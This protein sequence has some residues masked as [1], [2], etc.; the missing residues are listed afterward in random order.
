MNTT[1]LIQH[2]GDDLTPVRPLAAPWKRAAAW[3]GCACLYLA[4]VVLVAWIRDIPLRANRDGL[5]VV[6]LASFATAMIAALAAFI[7]IVPGA[8]RRALAMPAVPAALVVTSLVWGCATD[9][10]LRGTL[11]IGLETDW[12]CV[13]SLA[14]GGGALW[15]T[16]M[17]MLRRGAPL[18][19]RTS[20]LLAGVAALSVANVETCLTRPHTF[21]VTVLLWHGLT[22]VLL[23]LVMTRAGTRLLA[24]K[25]P[26]TG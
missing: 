13:A 20:A 15:A 4:A 1:D 26:Q 23:V 11:G 17:A 16:A 21:S 6:Q 5:L 10:R 2:L 3:L 24:W 9:M 12:P 22:I 25:R 14:L 18:A 8:D 19:P 7:S